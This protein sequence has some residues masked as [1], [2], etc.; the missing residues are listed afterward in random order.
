MSSG[1]PSTT[2]ASVKV[3]AVAIKTTFGATVVAESFVGLSLIAI[4]SG[5]GNFTPE[6]RERMV[7]GF[8]GAISDP[9]VHTQDL[10]A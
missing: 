9:H 8:H 7:H 2:A 3:I 1:T 10:E 4:T 6:Q 5:L